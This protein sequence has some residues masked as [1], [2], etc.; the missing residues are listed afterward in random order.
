MV[1]AAAPIAFPERI[2]I[3]FRERRR[4]LQTGGPRR[5]SPLVPRVTSYFTRQLITSPT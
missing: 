3:S 2:G 1:R 4:L 5:S